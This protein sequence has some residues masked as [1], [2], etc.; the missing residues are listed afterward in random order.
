MLSPFYVGQ[1]IFSRDPRVTRVGALI[2]EKEE[3]LEG[4]VKHRDSG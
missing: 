3:R 1:Y 2:V 4:M